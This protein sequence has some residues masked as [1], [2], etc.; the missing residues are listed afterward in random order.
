MLAACSLFQ[1]G[2]ASSP[3]AHG[4]EWGTGRQVDAFFNTDT[5]QVR[6]YLDDG[7]LI[8]GPFSY[9][10]NAR[11]TLG[12]GREFGGGGIAGGVVPDL[13]LNAKT[14]IYA[15]LNS[16]Q[17]TNLLVEIVTEYDKIEGTGQG[18]VRTTDGR[19]FK[20]VFGK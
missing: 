14:R 13:G 18:E 5:K 12:A 10:K 17:R 8:E 2:C 15:L 7:E 16:K 19:S 9:D 4:L 6:L 3:H 11:F 1:A 20:L